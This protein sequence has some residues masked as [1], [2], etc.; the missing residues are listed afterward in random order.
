ML[1]HILHQPNEPP[2]ATVIKHEGIVE[3][4]SYLRLCLRSHRTLFI[5]KGKRAYFQVGGAVVYDSDPED[6][7][8]E[9]LHK[10]KA[11]MDSLGKAAGAG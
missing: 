2:H 10:A 11:L 5:I 1:S 4:K 8:R 6:E 3:S 9:T 7:Y